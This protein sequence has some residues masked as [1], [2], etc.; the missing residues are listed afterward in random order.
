[1]PS[2]R[3]LN[4][5]AAS[6]GPPRPGTLGRRLAAAVV[7]GAVAALLTLYLQ[8]PEGQ[9]FYPRCTFHTVTGLLCPGCGGLRATHELLHGR[10]LD[11]LRSNALL[12][13][14]LPAA[15]GWWWWSARTRSASSSRVVW[16]LFA[17]TMAFMLARNHPAFPWLAP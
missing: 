11:A 13:I 9:F 4:A 10:L 15:L 12:V 6:A 16:I 3:E 5:T 17:V 14:G 1:M 8:R 7:L 2:T